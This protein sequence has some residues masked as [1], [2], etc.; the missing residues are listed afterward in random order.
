MGLTRV[1]AMFI[2]MMNNLF[3]DMVDKGAVE[4]LDNVLTY[5]TTVE[6][7]FKLLGK[8]FAPLV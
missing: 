1:P 3:V 2:Q 4:F 6:E 5:S 7:H 8:A